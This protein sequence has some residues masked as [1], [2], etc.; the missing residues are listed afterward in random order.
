MSSDTWF[1]RQRLVDSLTLTNVMLTAMTFFDRGQRPR[2]KISEQ[3]L[4]DWESLCYRCFQF[5]SV[6]WKG[7]ANCISLQQVTWRYWKIL[8]LIFL[9]NDFEHAQKTPNL[10]Y[11]LISSLCFCS[12]RFKYKAGMFKKKS[13]NEWKTNLSQREADWQRGKKL[14]LQRAVTLTFMEA[15]GCPRPVR[16]DIEDV[17][18]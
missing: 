7:R 5:M 13:T 1:E 10:F 15:Q 9:S 14:N 18:K 3:K 2:S 4:H 11:L 17:K 12:T 6:S 16:G 8:C